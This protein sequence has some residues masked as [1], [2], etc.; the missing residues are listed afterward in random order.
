M[1][2]EKNQ[3]LMEMMKESFEQWYDVCYCIPTVGET[4]RDVRRRSDGYY[5]QKFKL[6]NING[7]GIGTVFFVNQK[8]QLVVLDWQNIISMIPVDNKKE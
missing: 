6:S 1:T 2:Y 4:F 5:H 3:E 8:N 7:I